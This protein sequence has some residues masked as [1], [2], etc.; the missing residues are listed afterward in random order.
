MGMQHTPLLMS[1]LIDRG[2][3][4]Q[5][6]H[7]AGVQAQAAVVAPLQD[8][9][10]IARGRFD[11][12]DQIRF[13]R[14]SDGWHQIVPPDTIVKRG[15]AAQVMRE[16]TWGSVVVGILISLRELLFLF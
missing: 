10:G 4:V 15:D 7:L 8:D 11:G 2:A 1:R 14:N 12:V 6:R 5:C 16:N 13:G 9:R 3:I